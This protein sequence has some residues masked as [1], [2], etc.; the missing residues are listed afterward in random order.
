MH[1]RVTLKLARLAICTY[2][3]LAYLATSIPNLVDIWLYAASA[4][5][6]T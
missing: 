1:T 2:G 6:R 5:V 3:Q 4:G